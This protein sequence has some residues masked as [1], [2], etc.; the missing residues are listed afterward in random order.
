MIRLYSTMSRQV[1]EFRPPSDDPVTIY[2][3][4]PTVYDFPHIG[5]WYA[6]LRWDLLVRV[7]QVSGYKTKWVMNITDVG[8]LT[9]DADDGEDKLE[10]GAQ[11]EHKTAW[12]VAQEYS[13]YFAKGLNRLNFI[14]PD[15]LPK[16]TDNIPEQVEFIKT[17]EDE[18]LTYIIDDG[19]Y[20]DTSKLSDYGK[21]A[22]LNLE[23]LKAGARIE[24]N[25]QKKNPTDFALWKFSPK[26]KKRDMEWESPWGKGFPGWHL[27]CS[28]LI[29]KYLGNSIDIHGGGIDHIPVHHTN[30]IA[31]SE[32]AHHQPL[33]NIWMHS[34]FIHVDGQKMSKSLGNLIT[35]EDIESKGYS[36]EAFRLLVFESHY[37]S[38]AE[39]TWEN[40]KAAQKRLN[41]YQA[42]ADLRFQPIDL[43]EGE[44]LRLD[45]EMY[46]EIIKK[47]LQNDLNSPRSLRNLELL[48]DELKKRPVPLRKEDIDRFNDFLNLADNL[49]GLNLLGS[50]DITDKQKQLIDKREI[51]RKN[52]D[53][54]SSD[55]IRDELLE[56][57]ISIR[58]TDYVPIWNRI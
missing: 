54:T 24:Y 20:F 15:F 14:K 16:A 18:G 4:G 37:R 30:E 46:G 56:Q 25:Q 41:R 10:K 19:V 53:F 48:A 22:R 31:Q 17:L 47:S 21:L 36:L 13:D 42:Y 29:Q 3:C 51:F 43:I 34:N 12:E 2:T 50:D 40:L 35:L 39:F 11:R 27:E 8:H 26:D 7:L 23:N 49:L 33:A 6:F 5:N 57:G 44:V 55:K 9:S 28:T 38:E 32:S 1:E 58:D 52:K 45:Y